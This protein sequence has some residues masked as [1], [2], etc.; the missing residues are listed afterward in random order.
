MK[1]LVL[2]KQVPDTATQVKVGSDPRAIDPTGITWIVSPYDEFALEE[3]LRIKEKRAQGADEVVAGLEGGL[4]ENGVDPGRIA[5]VADERDGVRAVIAGVE[6]G[7]LALMLVHEDLDA[8]L[9]ES[10]QEWEWYSAKWDLLHAAEKL[11]RPPSDEPQQ[12]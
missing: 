4:R 9:A 11:A 12:R 3:A 2:V 7:D 6:A 1:M 5:R 8:A 10:D